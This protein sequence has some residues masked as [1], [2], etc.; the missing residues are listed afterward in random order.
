M[1]KKVAFVSMGLLASV[2]AFAQTTPG[3]VDPGPITT[4]ITGNGATVA[5]IGAGVLILLVS[6]AAFK[7]SRR[8]L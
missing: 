6:I 2:G 3:V 8:A 1:F 4:V 7:W 5:A